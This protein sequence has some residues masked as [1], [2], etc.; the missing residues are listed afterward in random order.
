MR[1]AIKLAEY[2]TAHALCAFEVM[3]GRD[4]DLEPARRVVGLIGRH[5]T[6][7][8]FTARDLFTAASR[9]WM[10]NMESMSSTLGTL[11]DY[12]WIVPLPEPVRSDGMRG[13]P[14]SPRYRA[15]PRCHQEAPQNPHN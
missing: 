9:S 4:A 15:H 8:E 6:F 11:I 13:R 5:P 14:P 1:G 12:G 10:P 7:P 3:A 2:F